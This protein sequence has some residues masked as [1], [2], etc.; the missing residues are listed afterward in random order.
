MAVII[1]IRRGNAADWTSANPVLSQGELGLELDT[2]KFKIGN[3]SDDWIT[4]PYWS[5]SGTDHTHINISTL[6]LFDEDSSGLLWNGSPIEETSGRFTFT[7]QSGS[8][9]NN[10][11]IPVYQIGENRKIEITKV[12]STAMGTGGS[13]LTFNLEERNYGSLNSTG[14]TLLISDMIAT[15]DGVETTLFS[16]PSAQ[17]IEP[18]DYIVFVT[19][20]NA[21]SGTINSLT[22]TIYYNLVD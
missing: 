9:W 17:T 1:Q 12:K 14:A 16:N 18:N 15:L 10:S 2:V 21:E 4:L 22:C 5:G 7:I 11:V 8:N 13:T 20:I 3:G 19:G 6:D